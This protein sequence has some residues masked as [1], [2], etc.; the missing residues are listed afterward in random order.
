M[1]IFTRSERSE[2]TVGA[3]QKFPHMPIYPAVTKLLGFRNHGSDTP[4]RAECPDSVFA[5]AGIGNPDAFFA[6]LD[7][8]GVRVGGRKAFPD[9]HRYTKREIQELTAQAQ[10]VGAKALM[11]TEKDVQN[12]E[13]DLLHELPLWIAVIAIGIPDEDRFLDDLHKRLPLRRG[14]AA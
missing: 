2:L 8:W 13:K 9:H 11:T 12:I 4:L 6:D 7:A 5:F 1:V 10:S 14:V 3:I